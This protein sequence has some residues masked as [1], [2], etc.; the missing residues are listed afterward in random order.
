M[1]ATDPD[2]KKREN[3]A[4]WAVPGG[5]GSISWRLPDTYP[6]ESHRHNPVAKRLIQNVETAPKTADK[7]SAGNFC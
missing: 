3:G 6:V 1:K 5:V 4:D 7:Q 2:R